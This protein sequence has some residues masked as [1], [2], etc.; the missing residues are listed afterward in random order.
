MQALLA[1]SGVISA[2][3][4]GAMAQ[5]VV[6]AGR[7]DVEL[8]EQLKQFLRARYTLLSHDTLLAR[9]DTLA[10]PL[11]AIDATV[12]IE[13]VIRGDLLI[14]EANTFLRPTARVLGNVTNIA[15]GL[16]PSELATI[17][18]QVRNLPNAPYEAVRSGST[19]RIV[20]RQRRSLLVLDGFR[21]FRVPS[22]DRVDGLTLGFGAGY[23]LPLLGGLEPVVRARIAYHSERSTLS[24]GGDLALIRG[25]TTLRAGAERATLTTDQWIR[26]AP[27]N[28]AS[29]L[30]QGKDYR[31]YYRADRTFA[32]L[33]HRFGQGATTATASLVAQR[34]RAESLETGDP[35]T[36]LRPDSVRPNPPVSDGD[37][38][39][40][41][42]GT[43]IDLER[44]T[45][46]AELGAEVELA[47]E[48]TAGDD[49]FGRFEISA[50]WAMLALA[51]HTL[52]IGAYFQG[53]LP[54]TDSLPRQRWSFVGGSGT[55]YT[56]TIA[57]FPGD[58]VAF[59][60]T[61][62]IIPLPDRLRLPLLGSPSIDL[63]HTIGMAWSHGI[64]RDLE[65]NL[66]LRLRFPFVWMRAVTNPRTRW[67]D[68][69]FSAGFTLPRSYDWGS[70]RTGP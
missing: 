55:L 50:D 1:Y 16:Y 59:I 2:H 24:G 5:S 10:G 31:N 40:F 66:G 18:G 32:S 22:Y 45:F 33:E 69:E 21:G 3:P 44:P 34:E 43:R 12:R 23:F 67:N 38:T 9:N 29:F 58:R 62:Y 36:F 70:D 11:L 53:P 6:L 57:E 17:T 28:S 42:L 13:G 30:F 14:V 63:L 37:I 15:G 46:T 64:D 8:D 20:G 39:S 60:D 68:F 25:P 56:F 48:S 7:G 19:I 49:G 65:Q 52:A 26:E 35:W 54:G 61:D 4:D 41:T 51:N 27:L 47:V